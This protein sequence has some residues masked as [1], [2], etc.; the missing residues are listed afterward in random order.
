VKEHRFEHH[1]V[2]DLVELIE[3]N[4]LLVLN[5]TRVLHAR[6]LGRRVPGGGRVEILLLRQGADKACWTALG[7]ANRPLRAGDAIEVG[8]LNVSV[9][10]KSE[11]GTLL[12]RL[13]APVHVDAAL[14]A[15]GQLPL[16]PYVKRPPD[17]D[18]DERYQT[19][20]AAKPGSVAAPTAGLHFSPEAPEELERRGVELCFLTLHIGVGTFR[21]V[22]APDLNQHDMHEEV[23]EVSDTVSE[24]VG[25]ARRDGRRVVAVGTTVVRALESA[26]DPSKAGLVKVSAGTTRL[27]IQP[28]YRFR[29]VDSLLT[30]FHMPRSTLLA[31]V[32][33][34]AGRDRVLKAY[35]V[36][37][38]DN[39]RFLS[40]GDAMW[41][42]RRYADQ[43]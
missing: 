7:K 6:L 10:D 2:K 35:Q 33:A 42:P 41:I 26:A 20:Y 40:Y 3:P 28:G 25:R 9:L 13:R 22:T 31:L 14:A 32:S 8:T 12:V 21:P 38:D 43:V 18:D 24:Q 30:N 4:S 39:Y 27:L 36:A 16:P 19:V 29:V 5:Q 11:N 1:R 15:A 17:T 34:F 23:F 37:L